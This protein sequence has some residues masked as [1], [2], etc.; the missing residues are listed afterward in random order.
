MRA[1]AP[2]AVRARAPGLLVEDW[3]QLAPEVGLAD[4]AGQRPSQLSGGQQQRVAVARAL[5]SRP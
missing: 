2:A 1:R 4:R 5:A 3:T